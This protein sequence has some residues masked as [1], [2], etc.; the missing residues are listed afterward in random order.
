MNNQSLFGEI[1]V[2]L[3]TQTE[4]MATEALLYLL[5]QYESPWQALR[6]FLAPAGVQFPERMTFRTQAWGEDHAIPDMVGT[7]EDGA[8]TLIVEAKFWADLTPNQPVTYLGRLVP[9]RPGMLLVIAPALRFATLWDKLTRRASDAQIEVGT[10][11][12]VATEF[13]AATV[14]SSHVLALTSWRAVIAL[15]RQEAETSDDSQL[16]GEVDQLSGLCAKM[17]G[18]AFVPLKDQDLAPERGQRIQQ[19]ADLVDDVVS[20]LTTHHGASKNGLMTGGWQST[21]GRYF[22]LKGLA[23]FF[24]FSPSMWA[25]QGETPIWLSLKDIDGTE[26]RD[27]Q[28]LQNALAQCC[29]VDRRPYAPTGKGPCAGIY[30]PV[31]VERPEVIRTI[32]EQIIDIVAACEPPE[33]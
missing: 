26:W 1:V 19:F 9:G 5:Q 7:E 10:E 14:G 15:I 18:Q 23:C 22:I 17:D 3:G 30:L 25:R 21:Y 6:R 27:T 28:R 11:R 20:E 4:D 31:G 16:R 29:T 2:R 24:C 12:D 32:I 8:E 33:A 13:R